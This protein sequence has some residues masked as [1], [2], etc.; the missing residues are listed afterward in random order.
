MGKR[1]EIRARRR[2]QHTRNQI[3]IILFVIAGAL[4]MTFALILPGIQNTR[5]ASATAT[6][7]ASSPVIVVTPQTIN[8][9]RNGTHLGDPNAPVK[10]DIYEDFRCSACA[11]YTV[12]IA[13]TII[14][15]YV[16]TGI[17]YYSYH[18]YIVIDSYDNTT[19][20]Y[21]SALAAMCA[22]DQNLFW[23]YSDT[24]Y[25]NQVTEAAELYS[26]ERLVMMAENVGLDMDTFTPCFENKVHKNAVDGDIAE[27]QTLGINSTPSIFVN[28]VLTSYTDLVEAIEAARSGD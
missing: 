24:L 22:A 9:L 28:G 21:N 3:L 14:Q 10:V 2:R 1:Q 6:S 8:A 18:S 4:L 16:E 23:E 25:A 27:A 15:T 11:Y 7:A 13:P 17:V 26:D 5:N 20:S 19:S 12:N